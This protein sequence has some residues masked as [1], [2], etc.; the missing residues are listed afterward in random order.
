M[1]GKKGDIS[2][3]TEEDS[4][5]SSKEYAETLAELKRRIQEGQLKAITSV[6]KELIRLYWT[7]GKIIIERQEGN[8]WGS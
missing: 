7:I 4:L 3:K 8:G 5:F 2:K 1:V 6:N